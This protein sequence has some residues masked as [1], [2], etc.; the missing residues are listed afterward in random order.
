ME[1]DPFA[2]GPHPVGVRSGEIVDATRGDRRMPFEL[3]YPAPQRYAMLGWAPGAQDAF[4]AAPGMD[5]QRQTAVRDAPIEPGRYPLVLYSHTSG[6]HRRQASFL[7]THLASHGYL[8][9]AADH[10]GNTVVEFAEGARRGAAGHA[11]T[12]EE[13]EAQVQ[14]LIADR[15]PDVR[16]L[17]EQVVAGS[18][19]A[20]AEHADAEK[21]AVM[22]CSFGGWTALATPEFDDRVGA[23]VAMAPAG[24][25]K[26]LPGILPVSLT[27]AWRREVPTLFLVA[28]RD[29]ATPLAGQRE[30]YERTPSQRWMFILRNAG[31]G[32]FGDQVDEAETCTRQEAQLFTRGLALAHL[33]GALKADEVAR[34]FMA[35]NVLAVLRDR[36][37]DA[38]AYPGYAV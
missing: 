35:G 18:A 21:V 3:W 16:F 38:A 12:A 37:V 31:H 5:P 33:E 1:Y 13:R 26:P 8:V 15:V 23:L 17:L 11:P 34:T 10:T 25:S 24:N 7:C 27:F 20:V 2:R 9:A 28:E 29:R 22:G 32:H 4:T 36:G 14:R 19:G 6:G 30:L